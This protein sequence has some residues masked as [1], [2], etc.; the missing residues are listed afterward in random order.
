METLELRPKLG[1]Y[2]LQRMRQAGYTHRQLADHLGMHRS[3]LSRKLRGL[4]GMSRAEAER[5]AAFLHV[6]LPP[7][8]LD[9]AAQVAHLPPLEQLQAIDDKDAAVQLFA[10]ALKVMTPAQRRDVY[11]AVALVLAGAGH[12]DGPAKTLR[13]LSGHTAG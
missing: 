12:Q 7:R 3:T 10:A 2:L 5:A 1:A 13:Q 6:P 4:H 8:L 9:D 11:L